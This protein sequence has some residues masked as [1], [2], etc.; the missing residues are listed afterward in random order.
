MARVTLDDLAAMVKEGFD[1]VGDQMERLESEMT[2]MRHDS[3]DDY[4]RLNDKID[5]VHAEVQQIKT[6]V[7][8]DDSAF[9]E[10]IGKL[11]RRVHVLE[12]QVKPLIGKAV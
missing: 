5:R 10:T 1:A 8:E 11:E 3:H 9:I 12:K 2:H 7:Q 4:R 6:M